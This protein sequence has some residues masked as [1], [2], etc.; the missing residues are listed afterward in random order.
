MIE[1]TIL[2]PVADNDGRTFAAPHHAQFEAFLTER[3]GGFTRLPGVAV[4]GWV[5]EATGRSYRDLTTLYMVAVRGLVGNE[6][7]HEV[8][9]FAKAHYRQEAILLRYLG[10]AEI[11]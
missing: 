10:V 11:I 1:V 5:D 2:V 9:S 7:L 4:G 8:A 3:L 6:A